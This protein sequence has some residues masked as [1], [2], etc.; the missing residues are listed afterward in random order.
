[1]GHAMKEAIKYHDTATAASLVRSTP[2]W[3]ENS[4]MPKQYTPQTGRAD[5]H[6]SNIPGGR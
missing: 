2:G 4:G 1:M 6:A 3:E 5:K